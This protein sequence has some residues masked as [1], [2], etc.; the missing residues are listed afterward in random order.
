MVSKTDFTTEE[1]NA[2]LASPMMAAMAVTLAEP[3][4]LWGLMKE[5]FASGRAVLEARTSADASP[6]AKAIVVDM[7]TAEGRASAQ[8]TLKGHL[9][10][11]SP[12]DMKTELLQELQ[13]IAGIVDR[14]APGEAAAF[15]AWLASVAEKVAEASTEGGFLGFGG[16]KVSEAEKATL[17]EVSSALGTS[18]NRA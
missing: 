12:G 11:R 17:A 5:S 14:K 10:G 9:S 15:K 3:S 16:V 8:Q 1:W 2:I 7:E 18:G 13:N 6:L 4:G